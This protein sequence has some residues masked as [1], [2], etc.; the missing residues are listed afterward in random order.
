MKI[1]ARIS[2]IAVAVAMSAGAAQA[3]GVYG[4]W[5]TEANKDGAYLHV[6]VQKCGSKVCGKI[7]KNVN[8]KKQEIVGKNIIKNMVADG[9]NK[10]DDGT[11]WKPD[12]DETYD[13]EMELKGNVLKVSGCVLGGL[14]CR[15]QNWTRLK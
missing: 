2:A 4:T 12:D 1:L 6:R 14:I 8:G 10:W 11:I 7:V 9:T 13:S 3:A 5:K 15:S